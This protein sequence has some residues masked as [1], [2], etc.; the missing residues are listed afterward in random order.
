MTKLSAIALTLKAVFSS[1]YKAAF[2][3]FY[4]RVVCYSTL[5]SKLVGLVGRRKVLFFTSLQVFK[6]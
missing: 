6:Y 2:S 3:S 1:F 5:A 4:T